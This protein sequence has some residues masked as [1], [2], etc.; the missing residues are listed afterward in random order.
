M[1][2]PR[3]RLEPVPPVREPRRPARRF[4]PR[5]VALA[6]FLAALRS[7]RPPQ[8]EG[9]DN[10][11]SLADV[12]RGG[13]VLARGR[14]CGGHGVLLA[15][16]SGAPVPDH[17]VGQQTWESFLAGAR[18]P[19]RRYAARAFKLPNPFYFLP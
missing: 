5:V 8:S 2:P 11:R 3:A 10:L 13:G 15:A 17:A 9:R 18:R 1:R 19:R 14:A 4:G 16:V 12:P 7:G 6:D